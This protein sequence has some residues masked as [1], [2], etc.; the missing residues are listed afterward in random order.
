MYKIYIY[1]ANQYT[2]IVTAIGKGMGGGIAQVV[3]PIPSV[4][5]VCKTTFIGKIICGPNDDC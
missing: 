5:T 3:N 1:F 2:D 4:N